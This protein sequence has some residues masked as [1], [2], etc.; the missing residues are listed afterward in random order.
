L[1]FFLESLICFKKSFNM[2]MTSYTLYG[3]KPVLR[4]SF[5]N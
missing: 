3:Q 5:V 4:Q 1:I 2:S